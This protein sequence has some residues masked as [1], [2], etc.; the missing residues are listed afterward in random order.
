MSNLKFDVED[1]R[2][3]MYYVKNRVNKQHE[4]QVNKQHE[5]QVNKQHE[6]Q[7]SS[8]H[9][10]QS[11]LV[12][13]LG[14]VNQL[15]NVNPEYEITSHRPVI[16]KLI[17]F[18]KKIARKLLRGYV[19]NAFHK[20]REFNAS[21]TRALN[22]LNEKLDEEL[23]VLQ[24]RI[25][26]LEMERTQQLAAEADRKAKVEE[27]RIDYVKFEDQFR[28]TRAS[29]IER[30]RQY[31]PY[32]GNKKN[33]LDIGCGRGEFIQLL[34]SEGVSVSGIDLNADMVK[35]CKNK[36]YDVH[37]ANVLEHLATVDDKTYDGIFMAQVIEHLSYEEYMP[38]LKEIFRV[39]KPQGVAIVETI[40][41]ETVV[42]VNYSYYLDPTHVNLVHPELLRFIMKEIGYSNVERRDSAPVEFR[43]PLLTSN[44]EESR[45][46]QAY[47]EQ[48]HA[49]LYGNRDYAIIAIK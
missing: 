36:G 45:L 42:A 4:D 16:G 49:L 38:L 46:L 41:V 22:A 25:L 28:G 10:E 2:R 24:G 11:Q 34:Q 17:V 23:S 7:G 47:L 14:L 30:Q 31:L 9:N 20:Q 44:N 5:D 35:Y 33:V 3:S 18:G 39:L 29:I 19:S 27:S 43:P 21:V 1:I 13:E 6:D 48:V 40:N 12:V 32:F 26:Q 37:H 15:W 8:Q